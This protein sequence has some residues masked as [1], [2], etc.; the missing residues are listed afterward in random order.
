MNAFWHRDTIVL[1]PGMVILCNNVVITPL[2]K[3]E[4]EREDECVIEVD[5]MCICTYT[6]V[7]KVTV[8]LAQPCCLQ[9]NDSNSDNSRTMMERHYS[10][11]GCIILL[12][13]TVLLLRS[14]VQFFCKPEGP[15]FSA[16][17]FCLCVC[18][19]E[20]GTSTLQR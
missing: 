13:Q 19:S 1:G 15:L 6:D 3:G 8:M 10:R 7:F 20:T 18:L 12:K 2:V 17:F 14:D 11:I 5:V 16:K 4:Q 9:H